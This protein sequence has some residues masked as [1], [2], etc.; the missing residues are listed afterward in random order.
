MPAPCQPDG[1]SPKAPP[2]FPTLPKLAQEQQAQWRAD[3]AV[4][5]SGRS[6]FETGLGHMLPQPAAATGAAAAAPGA[7][8]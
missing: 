8:P 7:Q 4:E 6:Y 3:H 1:P 5:V 2:A